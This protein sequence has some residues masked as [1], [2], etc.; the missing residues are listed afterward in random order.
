LDVTQKTREQ[1]G[2]VDNHGVTVPP[3]P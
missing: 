2:G 3:P 1:V